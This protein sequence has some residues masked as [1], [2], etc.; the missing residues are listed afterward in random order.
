MKYSC[1]NCNSDIPDGSIYCPYCGTPIEESYI[2][3]DFKAK[4][5]KGIIIGFFA[6]AVIAVTGIV[7]HYQYVF[8]ST[9][10]Y[11][12]KETN[13][14]EV[15]VQVPK[16]TEAIIDEK[17]DDI[18]W[19]S[20][21][22]P[23]IYSSGGIT[24]KIPENFG[25]Y[26]GLF[27]SEYSKLVIQSQVVE[28]GF[29]ETYFIS[30]GKE[31]DDLADSIIDGYMDEP[32]RTLALDSNIAG[33]KSRYYIYSGN[34]NGEEVDLLLELVLNSNNENFIILMFIT[35][36]E[37]SEIETYIDM[38]NNAEYTGA[39]DSSENPRSPFYIDSEGLEN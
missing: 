36:A 21:S 19:G 17:N 16:T 1:K 24:F 15:T 11:S 18:I 26:D 37:N 35:D 33:E 23:L 4:N 6:I 28:E 22:E 9:P 2:T 31:Y 38:A 39:A 3:P 8:P 27:L 12:T 5:K 30:T 20:K 32:Y 10:N 7:L 14:Q 29:W 34:M 25:Y 13:N